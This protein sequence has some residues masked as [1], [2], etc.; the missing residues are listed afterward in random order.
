MLSATASRSDVSE[1]TRL[2]VAAVALLVHAARV[3]ALRASGKAAEAAAA[4]ERA[5]EAAALLLLLLH[6]RLI[7]PAAV[8]QL[9]RLVADT[10]QQL[11]QL[12][13]GRLRDEVGLRGLLKVLLLLELLLH[14][15]LRP[16]A[17]ERVGVVGQSRRHAQSRRSGHLLVL[18]LLVRLMTR[19]HK[20]TAAGA[21][22]SSDERRVR[23]RTHSR[24]LECVLPH[25]HPIRPPFRLT[26]IPGGGWLAMTAVRFDRQTAAVGKR[27]AAAAAAP[28]AIR[29]FERSAAIHRQSNAARTRSQ[30]AYA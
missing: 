21:F 9:I 15:L 18:M 30:C 12:R 10:C 26:M 4:A 23:R 14:L 1:A 2:S 27:A 17:V 5:G 19:A 22:E 28:S 8:D 3:G 16:H 29:P 24:D 25:A 7:E 11:R 13:V 20:A 6:L